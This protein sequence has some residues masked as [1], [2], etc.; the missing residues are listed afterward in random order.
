MGQG[1][2]EAW[3]GGGRLDPLFWLIGFLVVGTAPKEFFLTVQLPWEF[4]CNM[5]FKYTS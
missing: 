5:L 3:E 2:G 4:L 1:V